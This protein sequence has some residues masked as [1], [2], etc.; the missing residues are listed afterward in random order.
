M[1]F[2]L[3]KIRRGFGELVIKTFL[4]LLATTL[5]RRL[6]SMYGSRVGFWDRVP[7]SGAQIRWW[8]ETY[9]SSRRRTSL[10]SNLCQRFGRR[11]YAFK[12]TNAG[13]K[14][15]WRDMIFD[16]PIRLRFTF[17]KL[18]TFICIRLFVYVYL[19]R[20]S[21]HCHRCNPFI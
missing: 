20:E 18:Y 5:K 7:G 3:D 17:L 1:Y 11:P 4:G 13:S 19:P 16:R 10:E 15:R 21:S 2:M 9:T 14:G 12:N 8:S 6:F